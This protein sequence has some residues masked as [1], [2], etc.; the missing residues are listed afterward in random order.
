MCAGTWD[1]ASD[2]TRVSS[3]TSLLSV[4]S[5]VNVVFQHRIRVICAKSMVFSLRANER[6]LGAV[7]ADARQHFLA[8]KETNKRLR[9]VIASAKVS[10]AFALI[11]TL[12][13]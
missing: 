4:T 9:E 8:G 13:P 10:L 5:L 6:K 2:R 11:G 12:Q 7:A 1:L 3:T